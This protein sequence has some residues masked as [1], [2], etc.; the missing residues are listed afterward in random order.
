MFDEPTPYAR[1]QP[2][3]RAVP[4]DAPDPTEAPRALAIYRYLPPLLLDSELLVPQ[5]LDYRVATTSR[6]YP[7][8]R[9]MYG[10]LVH[11][12]YWG[13][14]DGDAN[15]YGD[16]V[17]SERHVYTR[18]AQNYAL[19]R[20]LTIT[21]FR[22]D[23]TPHEDVKVRTK[24]YDRKGQI[25]ELKYRRENIVDWLRGVFTGTPLEASVREVLVALSPQ[26]TDYIETG[27]NALREGVQTI[28][29]D[30]LDSAMPTDPRYTFRQYLP[31]ELAKGMVTPDVR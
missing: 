3:E 12:N 2:I 23:G 29:R 22:N 8:Y 28:E 4:S 11:V 20:D 24:F 21:W 1:P 10:E 17:V 9:F 6:L 7:E 5:H 15:T 27:S 18:D 30:W 25:N 31:V 14:F 19:R 16:L 26:V 13:A